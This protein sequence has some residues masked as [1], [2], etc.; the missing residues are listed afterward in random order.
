MAEYILMMSV[1]TATPIK[2]I[3]MTLRTISVAMKL[4]ITLATIT[5]QIVTRKNIIARNL[6][7]NVSGNFGIF[8][9]KTSSTFIHYSLYL[10]F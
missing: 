2:T 7:E 5:I 10:L 1:T 6:Y 4:D 9:I 8:I 3:H